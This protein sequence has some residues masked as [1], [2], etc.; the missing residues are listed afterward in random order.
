MRNFV[1]SVWGGYGAPDSSGEHWKSQLAH[2]YEDDKARRMNLAL[3]NGD[4]HSWRKA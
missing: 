2:A 3:P 4:F 1:M